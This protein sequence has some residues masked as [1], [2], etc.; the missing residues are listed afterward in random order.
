MK[1]WNCNCRPQRRAWLRPDFRAVSIVAKDVDA[2]AGSPQHARVVDAALADLRP[3]R[4][5]LGVV[6][7]HDEDWR[8]LE[9]SHFVL[10][11]AERGLDRH[12]R[13]DLVGPRLQHLEALGDHQRRVVR[14]HHAAG[15]NAHILRQRGDLADHDVGCRT[16]DRLSRAR[17]RRR[18][19]GV[20]ERARRRCCRSRRGRAASGGTSRRSAARTPCG[21]CRASPHECLVAGSRTRRPRSHRANLLRP[22]CSRPRAATRRRR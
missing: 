1:R 17:L 9:Q 3:A 22:T 18:S 2:A 10:V 20:H 21:C 19:E 6:A 16:R 4:M 12:Q 15:T 8:I 14:Q 13:L 7:V 11:A 5:V